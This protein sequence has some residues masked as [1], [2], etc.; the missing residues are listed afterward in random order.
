MNEESGSGQAAL[1]SKARG[2]RAAAPP[3]ALPAN[4]YASDYAFTPPIEVDG[5][6]HEAARDVAI[7][8][9]ADDDPRAAPPM[10]PVVMVPTPLRVRRARSTD[11]QS[12]SG[13]CG[14]SKVPERLVHFET[15]LRRR[16]TVKRRQLLVCSQGLSSSTLN[17]RSDLELLGGP[18]QGWV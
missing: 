4:A 5:P 10:I 3:I 1:R 17:A 7:R 6:S 11:C 15:L 14:N 12:N 2:H 16:L 18:N 9:C 8:W 13:Y